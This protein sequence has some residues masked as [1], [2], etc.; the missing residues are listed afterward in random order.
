MARS[1]LACRGRSQAWQGRRGTARPGCA[2]RGMARP[3]KA[4]QGR[5]GV[6]LYD[7]TRSGRSARGKAGMACPVKARSG[8]GVVSRRTARQARRVWF[9]LR[10]AKRCRAKARQAWRGATWLG[11]SGSGEAWS[12]AA[13]QGKAR[14]AWLGTLRQGGVRHVGVRQA[15]PG[16]VRQSRECHVVFWSGK[17]MRVWSLQGRHGGARLIWVRLVALLQAMARQAW[18]GWSRSGDVS[19][20]IASREAGE[21]RQA[22]RGDAMRG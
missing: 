12:V 22:R 15:W 11:Q 14:Q 8:D 1:G 2:S 21:A 10:I 20:G 9:R 13:R 3:S 5:R 17:A 4:R 7:S 18:Q 19:S 16:W 6:A